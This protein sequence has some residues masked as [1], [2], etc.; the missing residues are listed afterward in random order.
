[1]V[2]GLRCC[3]A[4]MDVFHDQALQKVFRFLRMQCERRVFE[5]KL[6]FDNVSDDLQLRVA[7]KRHF[8]TEHDVE[9]DT[10]GP[11]VNLGVVVLQEDFRSDVVWLQKRLEGLIS[12]LIQSDGFH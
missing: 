5:M 11:D 1:M 9:D 3:V 8:A 12:F 2:E 10:H 7:W 6:S 4:L